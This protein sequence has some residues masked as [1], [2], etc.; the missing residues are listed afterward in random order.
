MRKLSV[1]KLTIA[2]LSAGALAFDHTVTAVIVM[3]II[4]GSEWSEAVATGL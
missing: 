1:K 2:V 4:A 3:L